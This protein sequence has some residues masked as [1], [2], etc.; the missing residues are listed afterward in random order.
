MVTVQVFD[1]K[2]DTD[3]FYVNLPDR[4]VFTIEGENTIE[5]IEEFIADKIT[6]KTGYCHFGFDYFFL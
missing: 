6:Y 5:E 4:L 2:Y 1:I 3:G